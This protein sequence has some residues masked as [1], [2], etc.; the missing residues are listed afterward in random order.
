M[1]I[2]TLREVPAEADAISHQLLLRAGMVRRVAA[3][4]YSLLPL[5]NRVVKKIEKIVREEMERAGGTELL[6]PIIQPAEIWH[7]SGR[8]NVY[9]PELFRLQDRHGRDFCLGPTHEELITTLFRQEIKSYRQLPLLLY[10]IQNKYRDERRPRFGLLRGRE[11]IMKD[12]Y[13]FDRDEEGL[14]I[15]YRKMY[16]A[17]TRV[18]SRCGLVFRVVEAD[19]GAIGG[20]NSHEF[21][22]LADTGEEELV[23]CSLCDYA[24]NTEKAPCRPQGEQEEEERPLQLVATPAART[25]DDLASY[26][27]VDARKIL[28]SLF[29]DADGEPVVVLVRGDRSVNETKVKNFLMAN[30]LEIA[31]EAELLNRYGVPMGF[32]GPVGLREKMP[33]KI[34]GDEE[35]RA[36]S[37]A[38]AGANRVDYHYLNVN[39]GRDFYVDAYG[40]FRTAEEGDPCPLC[41][42]PLQVCK[43]IEVGH[44]FKLGTKYSEALKATIIDEK[45]NE[46]PVVMGCYGI[47]ITRTMAAAVEQ[48]HDQ[49]GIIWPVAI[50]PYEVV[51]MAVNQGDTLH[52][53]YAEELYREFLRAGIDVIYD[54][55]LERPGV[56]FKDADL[57]GYPARVVIGK[58]MVSEGLVEI[59]WR[60]TGETV[61]KKRSEAV[62]YLRQKLSAMRSREGE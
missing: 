38:V 42:A 27:G 15:S 37:N 11:F 49:D 48:K 14:D 26:L 45:G 56:K 21:M 16:E 55:R 32:A 23:F 17:Y 51:L 60:E 35:V 5:G 4:V 46:V 29:F 1:L 6:L 34:L 36:L 54:D 40:D 52:A 28:K 24:A 43:G 41:G 25:V 39:P 47:G 30:S 2:P 10:Q 61:L 53:G 19:T 31:D 44:I 13:S 33:V 8:W 22:V 9:G 58:K 57:I 3:G 18:F 7:E 20:T 59:K 62:E 50:A 12:L